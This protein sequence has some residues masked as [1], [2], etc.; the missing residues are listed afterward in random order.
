M[1]LL[2]SLATLAIVLLVYILA[3]LS[4]RF[5]TVIKMQPIYRYYYLAAGLMTISFLIQILVSVPHLIPGVNLAWL[6][7][8]W[9]LLLVYHLPL[10]IGVTIS[11]IITWRYWSWLVTER[12]G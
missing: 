1:P 12:D 7:S 8:S 3:K 6:A 4:A 2:G 11:L 5:G 10:V 9:L